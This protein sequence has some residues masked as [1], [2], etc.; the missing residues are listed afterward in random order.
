[1]SSFS[2]FLKTYG[3]IPINADDFASAQRYRTPFIFTSDK[4]LAAASLNANAIVGASAAD[5]VNTNGSVV[6]SVVLL[7]NV[8]FN[9]FDTLNP[10]VASII[11]MSINPR[12]I[13]WNQA[14]RITKKDTI[15]GSTYQH[16]LNPSAQNN[17]ILNLEFAGTTGNIHLDGATDNITNNFTKLKAFHSLY[18]LTREAMIYQDSNGVWQKNRFYIILETVLF[19]MGIRFTGFFSQVMSF[20][21][22]A[23]DPFKRDYSFTFVVE[24]TSPSLDSLESVIE[25]TPQVTNILKSVPVPK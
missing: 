13:K 6:E 24:D 3:I 23:E 21:E 14:K 11:R 7:N 19:P 10:K 18:N 22:N 1:M 5:V 9:G 15:T 12:S 4:R 25:T 20:E 8:V 16:F 17:D 2:D